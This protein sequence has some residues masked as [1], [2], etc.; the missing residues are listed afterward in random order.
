MSSAPSSFY[1]L[2]DAGDAGEGSSTSSSTVTATRHTA[3]PWSPAA[4]HGG[5]PMALMAREAARL[6]DGTRVVARVTCDLLGPVP[7]GRLHVEARVA[8]P[9]RTVELV[10]V[11]LTD[12]DT[13]RQVARAALWLV[14]REVTGPVT[15]LPQPPAGPLEGRE[16]PVPPGWHRGYLDAIEWRWVAGSLAEPGPATVWMRPR[17]GLLPG[18]PLSPVERLLTCVDS[19]SGAGAALAKDEWQF[20]N[21][22]LTAHVVREPVGE[23]VCLQAQTTVAGGAAGLAR[24]EVFDEQ[25]FVAHS[26]QSLLVRPATQP[27]PS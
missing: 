17:L 13:G 1:V 24:A 5:P 21:T 14:P 20:M 18:E 19:A 8:R 26:A 22:E 16:Q 10:E 4:Q 7:V 12:V 3:G 27:T 15:P 2:D 6:G 25:G 9:G 23:W 11:A